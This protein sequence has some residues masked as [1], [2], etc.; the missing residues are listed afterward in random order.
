VV[1]GAAAPCWMASITMSANSSDVEVVAGPGA[2]EGVGSALAVPIPSTA[3]PT[4]TAANTKR[5]DPPVSLP[6]SSI[7][8]ASSRV[9]PLQAQRD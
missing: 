6:D 4:S 1:V 7:R 8:E 5:T 3:I 2:G 9:R